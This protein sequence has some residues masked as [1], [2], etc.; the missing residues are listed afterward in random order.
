MAYRVSSV[1]LQDQPDAPTFM[2]WAGLRGAVPIVLATIPITSGLPA[3]ERIFD[4]VFLL[5]VVFTLVQG[6]TL[7]L[8][9]RRLGVTEPEGTRDVV[10]ESAPLDEIDASVISFTVPAGSRD[11][12]LRLRAEAPRRLDGDPGGPRRRDVRARAGHRAAGG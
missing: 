1:G 3:A 8:V 11:G 2:S 6:P 5:V 12:G 4:V 7:P 10:I 9:A